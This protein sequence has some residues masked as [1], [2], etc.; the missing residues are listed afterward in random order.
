MPLR[1]GVSVGSGDGETQ[2]R[3]DEAIASVFDSWNGA[4]WLSVHSW[5]LLEGT[6][7]SWLLVWGVCLNG[8]HIIKSCF[9]SGSQKFQ[10]SLTRVSSFL[11]ESLWG[12]KATWCP[13]H[14][15]KC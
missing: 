1:P 11:P 4:F 13:R 15:S 8:G 7:A 10:N 6:G 14:A 5:S 12:W 3:W 9:K 2:S